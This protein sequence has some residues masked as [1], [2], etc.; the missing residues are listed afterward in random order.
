MHVVMLLYPRLTQL[1]LTGPLE[2]FGR[3]EDLTIDLVWKTA[4][5][6]SDARGLRIVPTATFAD[7]RQADILFVP[8]GPGS[9]TIEWHC[10]GVPN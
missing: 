10:D 8:G 2:V 9:V 6:V 4:D 3:F 1:D 5:P 7:C